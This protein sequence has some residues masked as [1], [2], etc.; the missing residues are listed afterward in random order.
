LTR[1]DRLSA[2]HTIGA[3][4][5]VLSLLLGAGSSYADHHDWRGSPVLPLP[6]IPD[7]NPQKVQLGEEMFHDPRLS[8]DDTVSCASCHDL[9]NGGVDGLAKP[10]GIGGAEGAINTPTVFNSA[11]NFTQF[12]DGRAE[13]LEEQAAGPV[14]NPV[15][16]GSNW[17]EVVPKLKRDQRIRDAFEAIYPDGITGD[18]I[19]DA[20]ATFERT[21]VTVDAPFDR[22]LK[23][24][25]T[26]IS[27]EAARGYALFQAYGCAACHQGVNVGGN[28][29]Q[30]MGAMGDYF[31]DRGH[32]EPSDLG[33]FGVTGR[34]RDRHVFKV[35]SLRMVAHTA[36]YFHDGSAKTLKDAVKN[37]ATYQLGRDIDDDD[38]TSI[39]EFLKSLAGEYKRFTPQ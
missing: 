32:I 23:G 9:T 15:E 3:V 20:I 25:T 17:D 2:R 18:N 33:R 37:M 5:A 28:M 27:T 30:T 14:H 34:D 6:P 22:F 11:Y 31:G 13:T 35:P 38:V 8:A 4:I 21:L 36:P 29:Y 7:V 19:V 1:I 39:I 24:D 12:W 26:A 10:V 16:M